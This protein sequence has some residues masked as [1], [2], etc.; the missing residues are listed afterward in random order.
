MQ[1]RT[2]LS[3]GLLRDTLFQLR[4]VFRLACLRSL[5]GLTAARFDVQKMWLVLF[6]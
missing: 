4:F 1:Q 6:T 5:F 3:F 2:F